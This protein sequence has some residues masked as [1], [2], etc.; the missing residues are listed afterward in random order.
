[1]INIFEAEPLLAFGSRI[2][3]PQKT[4]QSVHTALA[5][6]GVGLGIKVKIVKVNEVRLNFLYRVLH[7]TAKVFQVFRIGK[8]RP[9]AVGLLKPINGLDGNSRLVA[10][11]P[12]FR[13]RFL[14]KERLVH[15]GVPLQI[16]VD[17]HSEA[18]CDG[19]HAFCVFHL[20]LL[21]SHA[22]TLIKMRVKHFNALALQAVKDLFALGF[23]VT[24]VCIHAVTTPANHERMRLVRSACIDD[25]V[26]DPFR[27]WNGL[28]CL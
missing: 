17:A 24:L 13:A 26:L 18:V 8:A 12:V 16:R 10:L 5:M 14:S 27:A 2:L 20:G 28:V 9:V 1:M 6:T 7:D 22:R 19:R 21:V 4:A 15:H 3:R 11:H 23:L 25:A